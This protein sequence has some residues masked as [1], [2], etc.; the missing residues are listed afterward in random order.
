MCFPPSL[1][2]EEP[3]LCHELVGFFFFFFFFPSSPAASSQQTSSAAPWSS[4]SGAPW[5]QRIQQLQ[6]QVQQHLDQRQQVD[7]PQEP[8]AQPTPLFPMTQHKKVPPANGGELQDQD[9]SPPEEHYSNSQRSDFQ[10]KLIW[11]LLNS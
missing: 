8:N 6:Q 5:Q 11:C 1:L 9:D 7:V 4:K 3:S 2:C 10:G